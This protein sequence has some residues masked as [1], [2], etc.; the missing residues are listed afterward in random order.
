MYEIIYQNAWN[1][2]L[3]TPISI[4][5]YALML[6]CL[7]SI[8]YI[9]ETKIVKKQT[10]KMQFNLKVRKLSNNLNKITFINYIYCD[11][12]YRFDISFAIFV[13]AKW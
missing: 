1:N 3:K 4:Y 10:Y 9:N 13:H 12:S 8:D 2:V 7:L 6:F 11:S 5:I